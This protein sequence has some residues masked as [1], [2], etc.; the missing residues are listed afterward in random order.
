MRT[1]SAVAACIAICAAFASSLYAGEPDLT[2]SDWS[3]NSPQNLATNPPSNDAVLTFVEKLNGLE[4]APNLHLCSW[5]FADLRH[6][7]SLSLVG[8]WSDGRFC[9]VQIF[10]KTA[11]R[12]EVYDA[13]SSRA[14]IRDIDGNGTLQ[15]IADVDF[16]IWAGSNHCQ[17]R[18]PMIY[19][20]T[21][22]GYTDVSNKYRH[23]YEQKLGSL[24]ERIATSSPNRERHILDQCDQAEAGK[25]ARFLGSPDAGMSDA[26]QWV[27]SDNRAARFF[28]AEVLFD[29]GT[30]NAKVYLQTLSH[31]SDPGVAEFAS[32]AL[33]GPGPIAHRID[34]RDDLAESP[35]K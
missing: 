25:I 12:F 21:G 3:V 35:P 34:R 4:E 20:W 32:H 23:F 13:Q 16:T 17:A 33:T 22:N 19:A 27:N 14:E 8:S 10:D 9:D 6:S 29:I 18:W 28:A 15:L 24:K 2:K 7:G 30:S 11:S 26:I 1:I 5:Q 31:D